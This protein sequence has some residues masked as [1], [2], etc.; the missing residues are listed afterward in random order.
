MPDKFSKNAGQ[1]PAYFYLHLQPKSEQFRLQRMGIAPDDEQN[2][3]IESINGINEKAGRIHRNY[4]ENEPD[5]P[6]ADY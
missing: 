6:P 5:H 1:S 4:Q 2:Q 3:Q